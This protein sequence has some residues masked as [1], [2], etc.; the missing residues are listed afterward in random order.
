MERYYVVYVS[1][2]GIPKYGND[3]GGEVL[4]RAVDKASAM[5]AAGEAVRDNIKRNYGKV[6]IAHPLI[7]WVKDRDGALPVV[8]EAHFP[9]SFPYTE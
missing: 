3:C 2:I 4:V 8:E 9:F 6:D 7:E 1:S 5:L